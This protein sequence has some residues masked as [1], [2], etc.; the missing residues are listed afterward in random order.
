MALCFFL[1][2]WRRT[3][4]RK[5]FHLFAGEGADVVMQTQ[6]FDAGNPLY[7]PSMVGRAVSIK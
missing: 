7:N 2:E 5:E 6:H 3:G 4:Q 1:G